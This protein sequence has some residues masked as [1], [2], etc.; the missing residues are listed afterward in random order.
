MNG[1][2]KHVGL[3]LGGGA[4]RGLAHLGVLMVLAREHIPIDF[5]AGTSIGSLIGAAYCAGLSIAKLQEIAMRTGWR[6]VASLT[7][8]SRG[9]FSFSKLER[10]IVELLG[11]VDFADLATPFTA[12]ATDL[13]SG[14][15]VY[16]STGR[17]AP[18]IHA[19]CALPGFVVPVQLNG[20]PLVDGAISDNLPVAAVRA[21]GAEYVIGVDI[22]R[23]S[24]RRRWGALGV[25]FGAVENLVRRAGGGIVAVDCL[26]SPD[27]ENFSYI[28]F[29]QRKALIA[30]GISATEEKLSLIQTALTIA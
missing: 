25:G 26:I 6:Q 13:D 21:M 29:S 23:P 11:D 22:C 9:F 7:W 8:P 16:L 24:M 1:K 5:V 27:I 20:R 10:W 14:E 15:P 4:V 2:R 19:S 3:A 12:V 18:A 30:R 17:L 28:R